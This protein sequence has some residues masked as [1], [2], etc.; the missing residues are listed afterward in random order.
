MNPGQPPTLISRDPWDSSVVWSGSHA[1]PEQVF[2]AVSGA[3]AALSAWAR[4]AGLRRTVLSRLADRLKAAKP[5]LAELISRETG[6]VLWEANLEVDAMVGKCDL[7]LRA[8][9]ERRATT[10]KSGANNVTLSTTYRPHGV[11]A[12][13]GPFNF[14]GHLPLGHIAP[15]LLGGNTVVFKPSDKAPGVGAFLAELLVSAGLPTGVLQLVQG[16]A[17]VASQLLD[18]DLDAVFFTGSYATGTRILARFNA[19]PGVLLAL[20]MGGNNPLIAWNVDNHAAAALAVVQSAYATG[21]QRCSCARRLILRHGDPLLARVRSVLELLA[22]G[23]PRSSPQ[24]F[25]GPVISPDAARAVLAAQSAA[26]AAGAKP[27]VPAELQPASP[28]LLRPGILLAPRPLPDE[29]TFGPLLTVHEVSS[30]DEALQLANATRY[31]LCSGLLTDDP[32]LWEHFRLHARAGVLTLNRPT[33]GASS[34][35]PF[36]GTGNSG[37]HRPSAYFAADYCSYPVA[38]VTSPTPTL[39]SPLPP[40]ITL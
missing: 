33:T 16:G 31:G 3:R 6:K 18:C 19:R 1:T 8:E 2:H 35:L 21:G 25:M 23:H 17:A 32:R 13:L 36:G 20:E 29:E 37:N 34:E 38:E 7:T 15:A 27:L 30:F 4:D 11:A 24:P 39:P 5:Q 10:S 26:C 22:V 9:A 40:G 28:A 12:V 14:P